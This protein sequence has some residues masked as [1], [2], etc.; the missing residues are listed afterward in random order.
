MLLLVKFGGRGLWVFVH[1]VSFA[2]LAGCSTGSSDGVVS[3]DSIEM[4]EDDII[5]NIRW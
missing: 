3:D 5:I 1:V 4:Q 2:F